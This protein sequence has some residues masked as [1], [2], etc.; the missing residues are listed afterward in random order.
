[1]TCYRYLFSVSYNGYGLSGSQKQPDSLTVYG[2][3]EEALQRLF[4]QTIRCIPCGRTD[5]GVHAELSYCHCDF[6]F[7]FVPSQVIRSLNHSL[8]SFGVIIRNI[9]L[10]SNEFHS[11]SSA[12]TRTYQ[13]FFTSDYSL[14]NYLVHS[15]SLLDQPFKFIPTNNELSFLFQGHRN[16]FTLCNT[17]SDTKSTIRDMKSVSLNQHLYSTL[18]D[19]KIEIYCFQLTAN[20]FLYK[21]VRHIVG[22][23]LHSMMNFTNMSRLYDYLI[24][25]R[26]LVYPLAPVQG[27]HLAEVNYNNVTKV[28][29]S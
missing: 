17:A 13:Y 12:D 22:I 10:V 9:E 1:M 24:V 4:K 5:A 29:K 20:G 23:L 16:F 6:S 2:L 21:M 19:K 8:L 25:N 14:P 26:P 15:V 28:V 7:S 27:L 3:L 18:F 11:L